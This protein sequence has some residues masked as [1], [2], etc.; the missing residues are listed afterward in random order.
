MS[1]PSVLHDVPI[2][3]SLPP[4]EIVFGSISTAGVASTDGAII[5]TACSAAPSWYPHS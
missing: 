3:A 4:S 2:H 1:A 5:S